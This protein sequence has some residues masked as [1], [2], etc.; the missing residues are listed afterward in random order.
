MAGKDPNMEDAALEQWQMT[1]GVLSL[2]LILSVLMPLMWGWTSDNYLGLQA[3]IQSFGITAM[4]CALVGEL[5]RR[6]YNF[7]LGKPVCKWVW[8]K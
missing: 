5:I 2:V 3:V 1:Q 6:W 7:Q 4:F 8:Q